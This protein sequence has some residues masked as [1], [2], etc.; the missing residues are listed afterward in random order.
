MKRVILTI[1]A[2]TSLMFATAATADLVLQD[3]DLS[4]S[5]FTNLGTGTNGVLNS[6]TDI[7]GD[8]G[9]RFN[10]TLTG[11]SWQD[12]QIGDGFDHPSNNA[13]FGILPGEVGSGGMLDLTGYST[14]SMTIKNPN[15]S[16]WFMANIYLNTGWTDGGLEP[17]NYY[18]NGWVWLGPG[19][20]A[21]LSVDLTSTVNLNHVSNIGLKIGSNMGTGD[22]AMPSGT[23]FN[24]DVIPAP[25]AVV[26]GAIGLGLVGWIKRRFA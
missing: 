26:L 3:S 9:Y 24:V 17:D 25:A 18:Q 13:G 5:E 16:G 2:I 10:I 6:K 23:A 11:S 7:A 19:Q 15:T 20:Q 21:T 22:Y 4:N 1:C 8:P 12:I 14:Y